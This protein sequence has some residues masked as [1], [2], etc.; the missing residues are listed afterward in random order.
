MGSGP[1]IML[2]AGEPSGDALGGALMAALEQATA[3]EVRFS[4]IGGPAMEGQGL[5]SLFPMAELAVM[6][7]AEVLPRLPRLIWRLRQAV[8]LAKELQPDVLVT[9]NSP[10]FNLRLARALKDTGI[11]RV[12]YVAPQVWAWGR[13]R[14]RQVSASVDHILAL[15]PFEPK[16]FNGTSTPC[17]FVGHP[18]A[19][20]DLTPD[21]RARLG[22]DFRRSLGIAAETPVLALLPGS[23]RSEVTRLLPIF[24]DTAAQLERRQPGLHLVVP[25]V[26]H[27][28]GLLAG[29]KWP[30][31]ISLIVEASEK[32]G[33]IAAADQALAA[34]GSV[35]LELAAAGTPMVTAY[36][37]NP[38]TALVAKRLLQV[39][40]VNLI[41]ILMESPLVPEFLQYQCRADLLTE[42]VW[43]LMIAPDRQAAQIKGAK[44]ALALLRP[45]PVEPSQMA[46]DVVLLELRLSSR[47]LDNP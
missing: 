40:S 4:G 27:L 38:L 45:G 1:R 13:S 17:T 32:T 43:G 7:V 5:R 8:A 23:R 29:A 25:T 14:V 19:A 42:A 34:S 47:A 12:H 36:R 33:A 21:K 11:R 15:F 24:L 35:V 41:N 37:V 16:Y 31:P 22:A 3:G 30:L 44:E 2:I 9:I 6:G 46:A 28:Q 18:A 20:A 10:G 26:P 39:S